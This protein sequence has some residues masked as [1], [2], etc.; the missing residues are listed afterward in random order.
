[1]LKHI[2]TIRRYPTNCLSVF[3]HFV[4]LALKGLF[5]TKRPEIKRTQVTF[6]RA[7]MEKFIYEVVVLQ[8]Y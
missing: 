3:D 7:Q 2:Q 1:M 4:K 8:L 6:G 5:P